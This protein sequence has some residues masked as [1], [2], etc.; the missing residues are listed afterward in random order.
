M[1]TG[2][3][4]CKRKL[5]KG[6]CHIPYSSKLSWYNNFMI[7]V[8]NLSFTKIF[9]AKIIMGMAFFTCVR[10]CVAINHKKFFTKINIHAIFCPF[11]K[12]LNHENLELYGTCKFP[13][14]SPYKLI[15]VGHTLLG[16]YQEEPIVEYQHQWSCKNSVFPYP[17]ALF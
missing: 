8:I 9:S 4:T 11:T 3:A 10:A 14:M 15:T 12:F 16:S 5:I 7:F 2:S 1:H 13:Y 17:K 6:P